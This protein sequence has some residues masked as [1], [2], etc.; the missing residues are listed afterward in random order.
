MENFKSMKKSENYISGFADSSYTIATEMGGEVFCT[1]N[2][3]RHAMELQQDDNGQFAGK[4]N[5][6][7]EI[8]ASITMTKKHILEIA[9]IIHMQINSI[10]D[11]LKK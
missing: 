3:V 6:D 8:I 2:F 4:V 11:E 10:E 1:I 9:A 7:K 5:L